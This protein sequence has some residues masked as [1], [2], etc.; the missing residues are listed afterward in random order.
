MGDLNDNPTNASVRKHLGTVGKQKKIKE[1]KMFNPMEDYYKKGIGTG[2]YRDTWH[3]FDQLILTKDLLGDDRSTYKFY[4][5]KNF[6]K[7]FMLQNTGRFEGYP[8]RSF[9]GDNFQ[10]GYSDHFPVYLFLVKKK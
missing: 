10:G 4:Q 5:A 6:N 8:F 7:K 3:L 9:V 2:A 1:G